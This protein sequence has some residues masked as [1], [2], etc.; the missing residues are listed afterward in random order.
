MT[1]RCELHCI[2]VAGMSVSIDFSVLVEVMKLHRHTQIY[3]V[4]YRLSF[5]NQRGLH[6]LDL[7]C[8]SKYV[9]SNT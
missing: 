5:I 4:V 8:M 1:I 3:M 7:I 9:M 2:L 6:A